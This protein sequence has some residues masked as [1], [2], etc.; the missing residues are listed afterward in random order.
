MIGSH[1]VAGPKQWGSSLL[2][3]SRR[4]HLQIA[5][6]NTKWDI[7]VVLADDVKGR[8]S[9]LSLGHAHLGHSGL[10]L[11]FKNGRTCGPTFR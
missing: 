5:A 1:L 11:S 3:L 7:V 6:R 10:N 4:M 2:K 8:V 9:R